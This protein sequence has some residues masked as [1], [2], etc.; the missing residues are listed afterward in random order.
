MSNIDKQALREAAERKNRWRGTWL[1][2]SISDP[3]C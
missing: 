3:L 2:R 1:C